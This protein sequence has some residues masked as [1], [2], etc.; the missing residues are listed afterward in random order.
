MYAS[1]VKTTAKVLHLFP[2][3]YVTISQNYSHFARDNSHRTRNLLR[4]FS[5][6]KTEAA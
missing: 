3:C 1:T 6:L 4:Q 2:R 5:D